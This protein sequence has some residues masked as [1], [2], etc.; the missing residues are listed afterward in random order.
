MGLTAHGYRAFDL[1]NIN[2]KYKYLLIQELVRF[3]C[4][5]GTSI[6][7]RIFLTLNNLFMKRTRT[8]VAVAL[9]TSSVLAL[10]SCNGGN[11]GNDIPVDKERAKV[12]IIPIKLADSYRETFGKTKTA[13]YGQLR[14]SSF[15][16][17]E[18]DLPVAEMFNR[19]AIAL[20]LNQEGADGIRIYF[21]RDDKGQ[22][23]LVL[24]PVDKNGKDI[25]VKLLDSTGVTQKAGAAPPDGIDGEAVEVGQRCPTI[26]D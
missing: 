14:D 9:F 1:Y 15:L 7:T 8:L 2:T 4:I 3:P 22:V 11:N 12:H 23:R 17:R 13:L 19:D 25:R 21:G 6:F 26:C 10:S 18:F 24:L 20:L 16:D 5:P